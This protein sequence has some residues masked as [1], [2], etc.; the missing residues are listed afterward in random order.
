MIEEEQ[1]SRSRNLMWFTS[2]VSRVPLYRLLT[3]QVLRMARGGKSSPYY[4]RT[5]PMNDEQRRRLLYNRNALKARNPPAAAA[6]QKL[7][8]GNST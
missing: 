8:F 2:S 1:N 6:N 4:W 7:G 5:L 3:W